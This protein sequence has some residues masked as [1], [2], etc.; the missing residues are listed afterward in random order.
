MNI[1]YKTG[2]LKL[3][4]RRIEKWIAGNKTGNLIFALENG[5]YHIRKL[6][7]EGLGTINNTAVIPY[8][9]EAI[10]D[11]VII[12]SYSAMN[13]LE[14]MPI[15]KKIQEKI[16]L[17]KNYWTDK[18]KAEK[19]ALSRHKINYNNIPKWDKKGRMKTLEMVRQMLKKPM[20]IGKWI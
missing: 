3:T 18:E 1:L 10:D 7:A 20:N 13:S 9:I 16:N 8:L 5:N 19:E 6:A 15:D 2:L 12:V 17:K 11:K 4:E 14:K